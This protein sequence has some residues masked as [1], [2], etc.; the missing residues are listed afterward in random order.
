MDDL[1]SACDSSSPL[2]R[3][4]SDPNLNNHCPEVRVGL[5]ARHGMAEGAELHV[6]E[7]GAGAA[8]EMGRVEER[9]ENTLL[10]ANSACSSCAE[11]EEQSKEPS[12]WAAVLANGASLEA[13]KGNGMV[14]EERDGTCPAPNPSEQENIERVSTSSGKQLETV[15]QEPL[16]ADGLASNGGGCPKRSTTCQDIPGQEPLAP[17]FPCQDSPGPAAGVPC[18]SE[19]NGKGDSGRNVPCEESGRPGRVPLEQ[20]RKPISQSQ[21][22]EF[23]F[24]GSNW[25]SFQ[26][27]VTPLPSGDPAPRHLLSYGCCSKRLSSKALR[28]PG[29]CLR[30]GAKPTACSGH[31][32][33]HFAG[34]VGRP[35]RSWLPCHLK[36]ASGPKHVPPKCPSPVPPLYLDDDGLPF[37]TDVIQHRLRQIEASYKQEVEQLRRQVRELQLRLDIRH[38]CAPPAEPPMDYEDDFV[39]NGLEHP[40]SGPAVLPAPPHCPLQPAVLTLLL[41]KWIIEP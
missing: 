11:H 21:S 29:L 7:G 19:D 37:P 24:L 10:K 38:F 32:S 17:S 27:M 20:W 18:P 16:K 40:N 15:P 36:Q 25:D 30:E 31:G 35:S 13:E 26:G 22:S 39:S 1:L 33:A 41:L 14:T 12:G 8:G 9:G 28:A 5:E 2:T 34:A 23:S 6:G 4:S 3:T